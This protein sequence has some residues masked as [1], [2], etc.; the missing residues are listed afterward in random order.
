MDAAAANL[1]AAQ[2][3]YEA[4]IARQQASAADSAR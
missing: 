4:E 3:A 2:K 1:R